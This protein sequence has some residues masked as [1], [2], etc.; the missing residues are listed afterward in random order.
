M[1]KL[2][3]L[4]ST[5]NNGQNTIFNNKLL[6]SFIVALFAIAMF[7]TPKNLAFA[8]NQPDNELNNSQQYYNFNENPSATSQPGQSNQ[9]GH[10]DRLGGSGVEIF[11]DERGNR[12]MRT[13]PPNRRENNGQNGNTF[14]ISPQIYPNPNFWPGG[15]FPQQ[16][17]GFRP[18]LKPEPRS[19]P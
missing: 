19:N 13:T 5:L 18:G 2:K 16:P 10:V 11:T 3:Y 14:F 15:N 12:V 9:S 1:P 17:P 4:F 6:P 8:Q 7:F